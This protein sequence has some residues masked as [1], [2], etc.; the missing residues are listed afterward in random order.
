MLLFIYSYF[1]YYS[2]F[3]L[4]ILLLFIYSSLFHLYDLIYQNNSFVFS[5]LFPSFFICL[6]LLLN[7]FVIIACFFA[8]TVLI[9]F[10]I[11]SFCVGSCRSLFLFVRGMIS[12]N[13]GLTLSLTIVVGLMQAAFSNL[14]LFV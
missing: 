14:R 3:I 2:F 11:L 10:V 9:Y 4:F 12:S 13:F 7:I 5:L 6:I 1:D 8:T